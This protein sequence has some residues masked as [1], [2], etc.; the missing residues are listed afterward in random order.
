MSFFV[1]YAKARETSSQVEGIFVSP[2]TS[3]T[4]S[5]IFIRFK[6]WI[7]DTRGGV[8]VQSYIPELEAMN[9]EDLLDFYRHKEDENFTNKRKGKTI[10]DRTGIRNL[11]RQIVDTIHTLRSGI[12]HKIPIKINREG[13]ITYEVVQY[14]MA[15]KMNVGYVENNSASY[16]SILRT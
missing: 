12:S 14:Y 10:N 5:D 4:Y 7:F 13:D 11:M 15:L 3:G 16:T 8:L 9:N 1:K 6:I 2:T